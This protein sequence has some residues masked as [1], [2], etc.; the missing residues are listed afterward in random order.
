MNDA[1]LYIY[2]IAALLPLSAAMVVLQKNPF[3]AL[4]MRGI[5]GAMAALTY[6]VLGAADVA[7]TEALVGTLLAVML[8]AVA[9]RSSLLLKLGVLEANAG[10]SEPI[11]VSEDETRSVPGKQQSFQ[12]LVDGLRHVCG[13]HYMRLELVPFSNSQALQR[14]LLDKE[15]H[16]VC[17]PRSPAAFDPQSV[18]PPSVSED[19]APL[20]LTQVRVRRVYDILQAELPASLTRLDWVT[21]PGNF[22]AAQTADI[23]SA[24]LGEGKS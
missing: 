22:P 16:A 15:V 12:Q 23:G 18:D 5:L 1:D 10:E 3:Y 20:Y 6:T 21:V 14:A 19:A 11:L 24:Q 13:E 4:I 17:V 2:V 9:V 7:L 8:Y